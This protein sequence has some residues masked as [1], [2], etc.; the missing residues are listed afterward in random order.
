MAPGQLEVGD[1]VVEQLGIEEHDVGVASLVVGVAAPALRGAD[2][3]AA[4]VKPAVSFQIGGHRLVAA[5]AQRVLGVSRERRMT[6]VAG[7]LQ[8]GV[9]LGQRPR[10][11][12]PL[13]D[14]LRICRRCKRQQAQHRECK[15]AQGCHWRSGAQ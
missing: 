3:V 9:R 2:L 15:E 14:V 7:G 12:Q 6:V 5:Q 1:V 4:A 10:I 13:D 8:L 11:D